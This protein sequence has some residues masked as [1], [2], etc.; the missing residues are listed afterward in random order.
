MNACLKWESETVQAEF[1]NCFPLNV[2]PLFLILY[3]YFINTAPGFSRS[4]WRIEQAGGVVGVSWAK[5][6]RPTRVTVPFMENDR[7]V[8][9]I[10]V[11]L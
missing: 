3:I 11:D 9:H 1:A 7:S 2:G 10:N 5:D 4:A 6:G 8:Y